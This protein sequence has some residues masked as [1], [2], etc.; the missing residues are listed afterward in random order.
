MGMKQG[1]VQSFVVYDQCGVLNRPRENNSHGNEA[2]V[3]AEFVVCD[4]CDVFNR[5]RKNYSHEDE[6]RVCV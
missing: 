3:C 2:R 6:A 5:P 4:Q 1:C